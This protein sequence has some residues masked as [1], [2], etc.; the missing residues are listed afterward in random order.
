MAIEGD[1]SSVKIIRCCLLE[2][3]KKGKGGAGGDGLEVIKTC[4][5]CL[6]NLLFLC[7][8]VLGYSVSGSMI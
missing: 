4:A 1:G 6:F 7:F 2:R 3:C 8:F 5:P